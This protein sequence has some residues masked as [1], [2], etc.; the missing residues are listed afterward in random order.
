[1]RD[2]TG[3]L[4]AWIDVG[5]PDAARLH[6]ASKLAPRVAVYTH[7]DVA[8]VKRNLDGERIHRAES[9]ELYAIDRLLV[10][11]LAARLERRMGFSLSINERELYVSIGADTVTGQVT[12]HALND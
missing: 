11:A 6:K 2:L 8:Q 5:S 7:K 1:M 4:K 9:L 12:R 3:G 10:A